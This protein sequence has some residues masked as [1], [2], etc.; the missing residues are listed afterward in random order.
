MILEHQVLL[1]L[2][3]SAFL[4]SP[5]ME[6]SVFPLEQLTEDTYRYAR[7]NTHT[8]EKNKHYETCKTLAHGVPQGTVLAPLYFSLNMC[9]FT[10]NLLLWYP[11]MTSDLI[12]SR[13]PRDSDTVPWDVRHGDAVTVDVF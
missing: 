4:Q 6:Y 8:S 1:A 11:G 13:Y 9:L 3:Q 10:F 12:N 5:E 7:M 2:V